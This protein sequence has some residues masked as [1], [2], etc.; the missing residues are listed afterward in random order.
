MENKTKKRIVIADLLED[1]NN[2]LTRLAKDDLGNGSIQE[3]YGL[4]WTEVV[5]IFRNPKLK[6]KKT[7]RVGSC[8]SFE[9]VDDETSIEVANTTDTPVAHSSTEEVEDITNE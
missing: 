3:K 6:K 8:L 4:T 9:L 1:L 5:E 7:R 2:G